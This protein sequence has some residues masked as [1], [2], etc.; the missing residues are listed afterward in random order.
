MKVRWR[1]CGWFILLQFLILPS[2]FIF[3]KICKNKNGFSFMSHKGQFNMLSDKAGTVMEWW[4]VMTE[5]ALV[6]GLNTRWFFKDLLS[7]S[8]WLLLFIRW[9]M[10]FV[11]YIGCGWG[12]TRTP[13]IDVRSLFNICLYIFTFFTVYHTHTLHSIHHQSFTIHY[14]SVLLN[15]K[16]ISTALCTNS[17]IY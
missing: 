13:L 16:F 4:D 14:H 12:T 10:R 8:D 17:S 11:Q 9:I 3:G 6:N 2:L 15:H 1:G 5:T 7:T